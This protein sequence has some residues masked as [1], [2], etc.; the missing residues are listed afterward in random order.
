MNTAGRLLYI[1]DKL[2]NTG[3]GNDKA[4]VWIWAE[5]FEIPQSGQHVEDDVVACLQAIRSQLDLL[6]AKL[7]TMHASEELL[8]PGLP[9]FRNAASPVFLN[10]NWSGLREETSK[11][12]N[13]VFLLWAN[14]ALRGEEEDSMLPDEL[15]SLKSDLDAMEERLVSTDLSSYLRDFLQRQINVIR[16]ALRIYPV[17]GVKP[18][19]SALQQVTGAYT[20]DKNIVEAECAK[21]SQPARNLF[22]QTGEVIKK[23][24]EVVDRVDKIRK[25]GEGIYGLAAKVAPI[26]ISFAENQ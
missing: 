24:A 17:A 25:A 9:R 1:Y 14:W 23:V 7:L 5:I 15:A 19:E 12:E 26:L 11:P 6:R 10:Q 18:I 4:M 13:R 8:Q 22:S 3:W 16:N 21:A 2:V 20:I